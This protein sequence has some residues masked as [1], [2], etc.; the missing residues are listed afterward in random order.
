MLT[1]IRK[2]YQQSD[3]YSTSIHIPISQPMIIAKTP[4]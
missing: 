4:L 3:A 1:L 2:V